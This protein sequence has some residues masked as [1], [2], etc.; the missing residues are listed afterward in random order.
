MNR[1]FQI[2]C[3]F[4]FI[5]CSAFSMFG[6][7]ERKY[8]RRGNSAYEKK[9]FLSAEKKYQAALREDS[10]SLAATYNLA[11]TCY[12][13]EKY[14]AAE[15]FYNRL[16]KTPISNDLQAKVSYNL[17]NTYMKQAENS[18]QKKDLQTAKSKLSEA[19]EAYKKS[20]RLNPSGKDAKYNF[21]LAKQVLK[22]LE[23]QQQQQQQQQQNQQ[24]GQNQQD[25]PEKNDRK[26]E[27]ENQGEK[28][29]NENP[30]QGKNKDADGDGIPDEVEQ[31][32]GNPDTDKDG[33]KDF[34]D[35]DSDNDGIPDRQEAGKN[36]SQPRDTDKDGKPDYQDTDS[37]NDGIPDG[38]DPDALPENM[39]LSD[40]DAERILQYVREQEKEV[41]KKVDAHKRKHPKTSKSKDW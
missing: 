37:D 20:L 15:S 40:A 11:N 22:Q 9:D 31:K 2:F 6:Q 16:Q 5:M 26:E 28:E 7:Y 35:T 17:G 39:Q 13:L 3:I 30:G 29:K 8:I 21:T 38:E 23:Q 25:P 24:N 32:K 12:H 27:K 33:Q 14:D 4:L 36:P 1:R 41:R 19:M 10:A 34:E 18:L